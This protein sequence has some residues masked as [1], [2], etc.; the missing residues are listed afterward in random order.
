MKMKLWILLITI[1]LAAFPARGASV[2]YTYDVAGRLI[3]VDYGGGKGF[4][5]QYDNAGNLVS[6]TAVKAPARR[7][8][9]RVS[10]NSPSK[11]KVV[12]A[13]SV[14]AASK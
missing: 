8:A 10:A 4:A 12:A 5:Y 9:V 2:T 13:R 14:S 1:V 6:R 7:R 3:R 11:G